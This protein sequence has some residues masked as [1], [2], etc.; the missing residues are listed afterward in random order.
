MSWIRGLYNRVF[1]SEGVDQ[2]IAIQQI[3]LPLPIVS[4]RVERRHGGCKPPL[5]DIAH[6]WRYPTMNILYYEYQYALWR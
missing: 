3:P 2:I 4:L 6:W 1:H 5:M